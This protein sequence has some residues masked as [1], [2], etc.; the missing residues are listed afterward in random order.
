MAALSKPHVK[1]KKTVLDKIRQQCRMAN[2]GV[3]GFRQYKMRLPCDIYCSYEL[4]CIQIG[5]P[6]FEWGM[7]LCL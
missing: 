1:Q 4:V 6:N 2:H 3:S 7:S 5:D